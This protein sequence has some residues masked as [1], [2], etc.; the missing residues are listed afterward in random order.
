MGAYVLALAVF[1]G[2]GVFLYV[3][4]QRYG[5][6]TAWV[7]HT[8]QVITTSEAALS[9]LKDL[10]TG[11]RG[12]LL[13]GKE[14]FL[15][16]YEQS[17]RIVRTRLD[18]V[19]ALTAD[20]PEQQARLHA[21]RPLVEQKIAFAN[22]TIDVFRRDPARAH[23]M[24]ASR[25]GKLVMDEIRRHVDEIVREE[26]R[27]LAVR[28]EQARTMAWRTTALLVFGN[29]L[30]FALLAIGTIAL[31]RELNRRKRVE[32]E[33]AFHEE[34]AALKTSA[35][36]A[37]RRLE[38][39]IDELPIAIVITD[40]R[41]DSIALQNARMRELTASGPLALR[42]ADGS[43][44]KAGTDP[45]GRALT[46][47]AVVHGEELRVDRGDQPPASVIAD[48]APVRDHDGRVLGAVGVFHD[49]AELRRTEA[50]RREAEQFRDLFLGALG[51]DLRNPLSVITAGSTSLSRRV[52][53]AADLKLVY[54]MSSSAQRMARMISQL[55]EL[56]QVRLGGG[57]EIDRQRMD[58]GALTRNV[59]DEI[60]VAYPD[61]TVELVMEGESTGV[62]DRERLADVIRG[63][64]ENALEHGRADTPVN[65]TVRALDDENVLEVRN[66][67]N[68]I[69]RELLPLIF[70]PFRRAEERKRMK[71]A[72]LG[73]GL[74]LAQEIVRAHGGRIG[75]S[76][77]SEAGTVFRVTL[78]RTHV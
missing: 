60:D 64:V 49:V 44:Y 26:Q 45:I 1:V 6:R 71:S 74:Y 72:G 76:S 7:Q 41:K 29:G 12:Y 23:A 46:T 11:Q 51:H 32:Q 50:E 57:L 19:E 2:V 54:R 15:E 25:E 20:N 61:R 59:L 21:L 36:Q 58:L 40:S 68:P 27:L 28:A 47:G 4:L 9:D 37:Q 39:V 77:S 69:P 62:W 63:L 30:A 43:H 18:K 55:L 24:I 73:I 17:I 35:D 52:T 65:V 5:E 53:S 67:G 14:D 8:M 22:R 56:V 66:Q 70:D 10:E 38:A 31:G 3:H 48:A 13:A 75:V 34:R 33:H 16:P 78:P 42:H